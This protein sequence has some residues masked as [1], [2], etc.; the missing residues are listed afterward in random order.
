[1]SALYKRVA[2][3][4]VKQSFEAKSQEVRLIYEDI[5]PISAAATVAGDK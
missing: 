4:M 3:A 1:M 2:R 5:S